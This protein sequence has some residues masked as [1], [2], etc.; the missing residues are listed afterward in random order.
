MGDKES[1]ILFGAAAYLVSSLVPA[2]KGKAWW[3]RA[4][5]FPRLQLGAAGAGLLAYA[6]KSLAQGSKEKR[7]AIAMIGT[8][9]ALDAY[10][11]LPY[12]PIAS[13][14]LLPAEK[15]DPDQQ[16]SLLTCNVYQYNK[17]R[18]P[19]LD[20]IKRTAPDIVFLLEVD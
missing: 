1:L 5:D 14:D 6:S 3:V 11:I 20:L 2:F 7:A 15:T 17:Q 13:L 19:L 16:I 9:L 4:W 8:S 12:S 18:R 10:R